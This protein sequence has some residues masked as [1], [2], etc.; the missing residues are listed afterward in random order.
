MACA[1]FWLADLVKLDM[2]DLRIIEPGLW[3]AVAAR[4][5][6]TKDRGTPRVQDRKSQH[7]LTGLC[8]CAVCHG[9]IMMSG[10][11]SHRSH[12]RKGKFYGCA[13]HVKR[14]AKICQNAV[15][16][17]QDVL[18]RAVLNAVVGL[19]D[20]QVFERAL[21]LATAQL[22]TAHDT[23]ADRR[24]E[25]ARDL[26][27]IT[28]TQQRLTDAMAQVADMTPLIAKLNAEARRKNDLLAEL[29]CLNQLG[30]NE[31]ELARLRREAKAR[32]ADTRNL[33]RNH[34]TEAR[35]ILRRLFDAPLS[36]GSME[37]RGK[38]QF[39]V[40]GQANF[41]NLLAVSDSHGSPPS[42][43]VSPTG[44]EGFCNGANSSWGISFHG[45]VN[46]A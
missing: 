24:T 38:L 16:A 20:G 35:A 45:F 28:R 5:A 46:A 33:L 9:P 15:M 41:S 29:D 11:G 39:M 13:Y 36:F 31:V 27:A 17:E 22:R 32:L 44:L 21:H 34:P 12:R 26:D 4:L 3:E 2:P 18:E 7:L 37:E 19:L 23:Q 14:G 6:R 1:R 25:I 43:M 30:P 42:Y 40:S 8:R 10:P